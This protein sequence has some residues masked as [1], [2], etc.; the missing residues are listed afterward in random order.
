VLKI[1]GFI[2]QFIIG[3]PIDLSEAGR[4]EKFKG[5]ADRLAVLRIAT[6]VP[7]NAGP[8]IGPPLVLLQV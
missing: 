1:H 3:L 7:L 5:I 8:M 4:E 2:E 6:S